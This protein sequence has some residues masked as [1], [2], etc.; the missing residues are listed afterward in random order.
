MSTD[1]GGGPAGLFS[2]NG[3]NWWGCCEPLSKLGCRPDSG[4][5]ET[6]GPSGGD[7]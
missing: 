6:G 7:L 2:P 3:N 4:E 5:G 1:D